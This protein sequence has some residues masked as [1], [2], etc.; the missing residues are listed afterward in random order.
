MIVRRTE[1]GEGPTQLLWRL[2]GFAVPAP[3]LRLLGNY[4]TPITFPDKQRPRLGEG[5]SAAINLG[6]LRED[7]SNRGPARLPLVRRR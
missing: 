7:P 3:S 2:G 1:K 6:C 5:A 4:E